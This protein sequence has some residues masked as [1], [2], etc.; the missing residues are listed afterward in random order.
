MMADFIARLLGKESIP[1]VTGSP[2]W[3]DHPD[4]IKRLIIAQDHPANH[5]TDIMRYAETCPSKELLEQHVLKYEAKA[6]IFYG[7]L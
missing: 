4:L 6:G 2:V 5:K 3:K 7:P 1:E